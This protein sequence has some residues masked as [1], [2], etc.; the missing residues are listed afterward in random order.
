MD[1]AREVEAGG[2]AGSGVIVGTSGTAA[3]M[4]GGVGTAGSAGCIAAAPTPMICTNDS[5]CPSGQYCDTQTCNSSCSCVNGQMACTNVCVHGC[6]TISCTAAGEAVRAQ[7]TGPNCE[8]VA[9]VNANATQILGY[10]VVCGAAQT[11]SLDTLTA[12]LLPVSRVNWSEA[13][14]YGSAADAAYLFVHPMNPYDVIAF[15]ES[16]GQT[17]FEF[18]DGLSPL[19]SGTWSPGKDL[20]GSCNG[21]SPTFQSLG[22]WDPSYP[23]QAAVD[24]VYRKGLLESLNQSFGGYRT[25][26]VVRATLPAIEYFVIVSTFVHV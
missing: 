10:R 9:R 7:L 5:Q 26:S 23:G 18:G 20:D 2:A 13:T 17:L 19:V 6:K 24:L 22:P 25:I 14:S 12:Q 21:P 16:T 15:S 8:V 4:A 1:S 11:V 3:G